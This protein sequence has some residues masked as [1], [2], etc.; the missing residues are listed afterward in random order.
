M[1]LFTK[2]TGGENK[3]RGCRAVLGLRAGARAGAEIAGATR[4]R[5][6]QAPPPGMLGP[7]L[8][9]HADAPAVHVVDA[10]RLVAGV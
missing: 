1:V 5:P 3:K 7:R 2:Y 4:P 9:L 6:S 8:H 10:R